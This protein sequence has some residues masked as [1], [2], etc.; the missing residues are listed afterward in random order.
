MLLYIST[1]KIWRQIEKFLRVQGSVS[2]QQLIG[3]KPK[4]IIKVSSMVWITAKY[5]GLKSSSIYA[6]IIP[7]VL[8]A[9][10]EYTTDGITIHYDQRV[11]TLGASYCWQ[12]VYWHAFE[13]CEDTRE[14]QEDTHVGEGRTFEYTRQYP[15][16]RIEPG[17]LGQWCG[18]TAHCTTMV[19]LKGAYKATRETHL[20]IKSTHLN[21]DHELMCRVRST[22][23]DYGN[24]ETCSTN[25]EPWVRSL[26]VFHCRGITKRHSV[27]HHWWSIDPDSICMTFTRLP[28]ILASP[29]WLMNS[30]Q[31]HD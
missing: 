26:V 30:H 8:G 20:Y 25:V 17:T 1:F 4:I 19:S 9:G 14:K 23:C 21:W 2:T 7:G 16:L 3:S 31:Q 28:Y 24:M 27:A 5:I 15:E 12:S 18:N 11:H 13:R 22:L 10:W 6:C 29:C